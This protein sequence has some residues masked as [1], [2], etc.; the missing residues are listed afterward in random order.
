MRFHEFIDGFVD[1][2][3]LALLLVP[4]YFAATF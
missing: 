1:A 2:R 4:F 3:G